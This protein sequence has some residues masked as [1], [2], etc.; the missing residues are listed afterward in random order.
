MAGCR[1]ND[2]R[3]RARCSLSGE[4][5]LWGRGLTAHDVLDVV[6]RA[7]GTADAEQ[8]QCSLVSSSKARCPRLVRMRT[9]LARLSVREP[10]AEASVR[11]AFSTRTASM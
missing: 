5:A 11:K 8:R 10:G 9:L 1:R 3:E 6:R 7:G 2:A 4:G